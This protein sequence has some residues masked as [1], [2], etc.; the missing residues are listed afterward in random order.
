MKK[1]YQLGVMDLFPI[2]INKTC[3]E[4]SPF[5][6]VQFV[7]KVDAERLFACN[8]GYDKQYYLEEHDKEF[9]F[10]NVNEENRPL[11]Y[12][13][14]TNGF[15]WQ[16]CYDDYHVTFEWCHAISDGRGGSEFF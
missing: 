10:F 12:G 7:E 16:I 1:R 11:K 6:K 15:L 3:I 4:N 14:D 9:S 13:D 2:L 8:I 5:F